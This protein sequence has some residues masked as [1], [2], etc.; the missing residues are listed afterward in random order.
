M[1]NKLPQLCDWDKCTA[2]T[3]CASSCPQFAIT[4]QEN[5]KGELFPFVDEEKCI[6]CGLC[7]KTCPEMND[8]LSRN[9]L[10]IVYGCW[11]KNSTNRSQSTSGG[12]A[13]A[14]SCTVIE[15]GGHV[16]GAAFADDM[17]PVYVEANT[18]EGLRQI[19]KSK[20]VQCALRDCFRKIKEEL[21]NGELV[22]FTGTSCHVKGLLSFLRKKYDNL[23]TLDLVCHGVPG[24]GVFRKYKDYL[25]NRY[26]DKLDFFTFR[27]KRIH[28]CQEESY[29]ALAHFTNKGDVKIR[30]IENGYLT[31][32]Y[33]SIFL[34]E[35]CY[36]CKGNGCQRYTDFT[37]ADFWGIG[38]IKPF[39]LWRERT[40]GVSMLALNTP[41]AI[42]FFEKIKEKIEYELRSIEEA[43][44]CNL[45][46]IQSAVKSSKT[47]SFWK[48]WCILEW[49]ELSVKYFMES[50]KEKILYVI[51]KIF[52]PICHYMLKFWRS[53]AG[54]INI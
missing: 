40:R 16:W 3:A 8:S 37:V 19:Q 39:P 21:D 18:I 36:D 44:F 33:R 1:K 47:E 32:F 29:Y 30:K 28:D 9:E 11:L 27:P 22:L 4:M 6:G 2:C 46:Y 14:I 41:N 13:Y 25:E 31:G 12:A 43:T 48:D 45:P 15:Q 10:S 20:Y 54:K 38:K 51:K 23:L 34:R 42:K 24:Q 50:R 26:N 53:G 5:E 17:S 49:E 35:C 7:E 52:P